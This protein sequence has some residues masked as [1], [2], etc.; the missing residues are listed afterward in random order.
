M[1]RRFNGRKAAVAL[2]AA[3]FLVLQTVLGAFAAGARPQPAQVDL[4]GN[5]LCTHAGATDL[6]DAP[7]HLPDC[8]VLGC[9]MAAPLLAGPPPAT[10]LPA[11]PRSDVLVF[12]AN[13]PDHLSFA[14][15]RSPAI[16]RAPPALA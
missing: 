2:G 14:R 5:V 3:C 4:F 7:R 16:P 6:P 8:C 15:Q 10:A 9:N 1:Q 12:A 11:V 13:A